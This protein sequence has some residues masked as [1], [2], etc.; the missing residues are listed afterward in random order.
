M[1]NYSRHRLPQPI[2][3]EIYRFIKD[4]LGLLVQMT[5]VMGQGV[6]K[7][8]DTTYSLAVRNAGTKGKGLTAGD[9]TVAVM[10]PPNAVV[11]DTTGPGYNGVQSN[12]RGDRTTVGTAAT[13]KIDS[14]AAGE[15]LTFTI[16][17]AGPPAPAA[18]LF[19][20]SIVQW[21]KPVMRPGARDLAPTLRDARNTRDDDYRPVTFRPAAT[22]QTAPATAQF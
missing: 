9:I 4:D 8:P 11:A 13:W 18:E 21:M 22:P 10:L 3:R 16:T 12:V 5:A 7:G 14:L 6:P 1:G 20:D 15:E 17:L 2:L 19:R